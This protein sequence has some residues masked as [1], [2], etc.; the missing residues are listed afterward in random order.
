MSWRLSSSP[1]RPLRVYHVYLIS[2]RTYNTKHRHWKKEQESDLENERSGSASERE[3]E[4]ER[5][6]VETDTDKV[7]SHNWAIYSIKEKRKRAFCLL[8]CSFLLLGAQ[9]GALFSV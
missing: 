9:M 6:E 3:R 2:R 7:H 4:R 1:L 5:G 8:L